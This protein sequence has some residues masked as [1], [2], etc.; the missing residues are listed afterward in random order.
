MSLRTGAEHLVDALVANETDVAYGVPGE[1]FLAVLDAIHGSNGAVR[2]IT[3]RQEAGAA[4]MAEAHGK[5]TGR[6]G[7]CLVTR[8]PGATQASV[9]VHTARQDSTPMILLIG[10][11]SREVRDREAFQEIDYRTFFQQQAKWVAEISDPARVPEYIARAFSVA[12]NG[13][14]GPVV[15]S[16]PEDMLTQPAEALAIPRIEPARGGITPEDIGRLKTMLAQAKRPFVIYGG[17]KW[18]QETV[19]LAREFVEANDLPVAC[20]FR[21]KDHYDNT[22]ANYAGDLGVSP[23]PRLVERIKEA[24]L[25]IAFGP[26]LGEMTTSGYEILQPPVL[27]RQRLVHIHPGAEELG[28]V[29]CP[30]LAINASPNSAAAALAQIRV[31]T[32]A[33]KGHAARANEDYRVYSSPVAVRR[34]VNL[35]EVFHWMSDNLPEDTIVTNGAGNYAAW[36]HRF[37][38]HR[39][40]RTQLGPMS[41]AMGYGVPAG[42][43]AKLQNPDTAVVSV[44][45]DGC[46]LMCAQELAT[47]VQYRANV[48]FLVCDNGSYGTIRMHQE[49]HYP[50][51]VEG[52]TLQNPDFVAFAESFGAKGFYVESADMFPKAFEAALQC[53]LPC[54]LHLRCD[55]EEIAP[56]Q[57]IREIRAS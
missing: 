46:F 43:A 53:D 19:D 32:D 14:P 37:Y 51:R 45:G 25:L 4:N 40:C 33:W 44:N 20:S 55:I 11:V 1:S 56:G 48:I 52:T 3:C 54:L 18:D 36:L 6:P 30:D 24:D 5:M 34:G 12:M 2:F 39:R 57:T 28:K 16:L 17:S 22:G 49:R 15:L 8:G 23:D 29:F 47:A 42:I 26:R 35:S 27:E 41:G 7:I 31:S 13:R 21:S 38:R 10:Q 50:G 9:G